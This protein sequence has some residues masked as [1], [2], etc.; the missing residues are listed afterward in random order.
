MTPKT[1]Y[2]SSFTVVSLKIKFNTIQGLILK[3]KD[4]QKTVKPI[5]LDHILTPV[6]YDLLSFTLFFIAPQCFLGFPRLYAVQLL[7]DTPVGVLSQN[8]YSFRFGIQLFYLLG[9]SDSV[10]GV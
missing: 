7:G 6:T 5:Q 8:Y 10:E 9:M 4:A 1:R 2:L 3:H